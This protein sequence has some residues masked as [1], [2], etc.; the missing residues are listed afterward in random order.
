MSAEH[1]AACLRHEA[2][3]PG[4]RYINDEWG[5]PSCIGTVLIY[6]QFPWRPMIQP[7][8]R[9]STPCSTRCGRGKPNEHLR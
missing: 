4:A 6:K 1:I 7:K 5:Y 8:L 9:R 2:D 3:N